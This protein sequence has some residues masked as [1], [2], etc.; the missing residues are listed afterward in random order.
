MT[1]VHIDYIENSPQ[2]TIQESQLPP[3]RLL[4][5]FSAR[6]NDR[7][8]VPSS[9]VCTSIFCLFTLSICMHLYLPSPVLPCSSLH[10]AHVTSAMLISLRKWPKAGHAKQWRWAP[11]SARLWSVAK[12][13]YADDDSP[14][15]VTPLCPENGG[16]FFQTHLRSTEISSR[17]DHIDNLPLV[18][19]II[20]LYS[21]TI[22]MYSNESNITK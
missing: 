17:Q 9:P 13:S 12:G 16:A 5:I 1:N 18:D 4:H 10:V 2:T 6:Y 21:V 22:L 7:E 3:K 11:T 20:L 14:L 15:A 8:L 19:H